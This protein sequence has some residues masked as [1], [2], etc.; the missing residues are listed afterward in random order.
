MAT[1]QIGIEPNLINLDLPNFPHPLYRQLIL[2]PAGVHYTAGVNLFNDSQWHVG[3]G[4]HRPK[5]AA[6][7]DHETLDLI[8]DLIPHFQ[9]AVK[10][11]R[12][13]MRL[14]TRNQT[15]EASLSQLALGIVITNESGK[16]EYINPVAQS[17]FEYHPAISISGH[18]VKAFGN[19]QNTELHRAIQEIA[20]AHSSHVGNVTRAFGLHHPDSYTPLAIMLTPLKDSNF[21]EYNLDG[22]ANVLISIADPDINIRLSCHSLQ[23]AYNLSKSEANVAIELANGLTLEKISKQNQVSIE[24]VRSQ[25]KSIFMKTGKNRQAD[26]VRLLLAGPFNMNN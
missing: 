5:Q 13:F 4:L 17:L 10:I 25:L 26:L 23:Q 16:A 2:K 22:Q 15:L 9:R 14:R 3:I 12:E 1:K 20:Q 19:T 8:N 7:F 11:Q 6:A 18:Q 21:S 24:T